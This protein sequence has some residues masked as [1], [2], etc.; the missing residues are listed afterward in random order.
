MLA[1]LMKNNDNKLT[2]AIVDKSN[3]FPSLTFILK[4]FE[5]TKWNTVV[6]I[7]KEYLHYKSNNI[8]IPLNYFEKYIEVQKEKI[9]D[10]E[11]LNML[12][13]ELERL[14][15]TSQKIFDAKRN[16]NVF[17]SSFIK[18]RFNTTWRE[19]LNLLNIP[20]NKYEYRLNKNR[21]QEIINSIDNGT[22]DKKFNKNEII[23][24]ILNE[25]K[26]LEGYNYDEI[27]LELNGKFIMNLEKFTNQFYNKIIDKV[28]DAINKN[29]KKEE[30]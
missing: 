14:N 25:I 18:R 2:F 6:E 3:K 15:T 9:T 16:K 5:V 21:R 27:K 12:K 7:T 22:D 30:N 10:E 19:L 23:L 8:D 20:Y 11:I 1:E 29:F 26:C 17:A 24:N 13:N 4:I 28:Y